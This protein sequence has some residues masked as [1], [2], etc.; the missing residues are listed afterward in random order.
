MRVSNLRKTR[1]DVE[2]EKTA[3]SLKWQSV[4]LAKHTH[5]MIVA[6]RENT[7]NTNSSQGH[8]K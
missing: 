7:L 1:R 6:D 2:R 3:L 4:Y 5:T 8:I